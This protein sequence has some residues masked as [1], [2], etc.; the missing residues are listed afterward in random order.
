V[1][2][3]WWG[4]VALPLAALSLALV[5]YTV[6]GSWLVLE[7]W[8]SRRTAQANYEPGD[9][10][11]MRVRQAAWVMAAPKLRR[12]RLGYGCTLL[13]VRGINRVSKDGWY[14]IEDALVRSVADVDKLR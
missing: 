10:A 2:E 5:V 14:A 3:F 12:F 8:F 6:I 13:Y 9:S 1:S 11:H 7:H 4:V